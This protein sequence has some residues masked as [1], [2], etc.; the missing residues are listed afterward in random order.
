MQVFGTG[1]R[2]NDTFSK[3][4]LG[5]MWL[6]IFPALSEAASVPTPFGII[7]QPPKQAVRGQELIVRCRIRENE[8]LDEL[9]LRFRQGGQTQYRSVRMQLYQGDRYRIAIEPSLLGDGILEYYIVAVDADRKW[10][11]LFASARKPQVVKIIAPKKDKIAPPTQREPVPSAQPSTSK[12]RSS[13]VRDPKLDDASTVI[14]ATR[15]EQLIQHAPAVITV[16][17]SEDIQASGWRNVVDLLRYTV[18]IDINDNGHSPDLGIRGLNPSMSFGDKLQILVDG[19]N[20]VWRQFNRNYINPSWVSIDNIRRIEII[21][22]PG[23]ALW[24]AN[25]MSG[26]INIITKS[27]HDLQ[28]LQGLIGGSPLTGSYFLTLQGGQEIFGQIAFRA[29]FSMHQDHRSPIL[30]SIYEFQKTDNINYTTPNVQA[31]SR[32]FYAQLTWR[33]LN[34]RFQ[35]SH[36]HPSASLTSDTLLAGSSSIGSQNS[37]P[38]T[39]RYI[40]RAS[41]TSLLGIWGSIAAWASYDNYGFNSQNRLEI[42]SLSAFNSSAHLKGN[43]PNFAIYEKTPGSRELAFKGYYPACSEL[44]PDS[45]L[46]CIKL[47]QGERLQPVC[48]LVA[49][50]R[51]EP[52]SGTLYPY[53]PFI[54]RDCRLAYSHGQYLIQQ[55]ALDHRFEAGLLFSGQFFDALSISAGLELEYLMALSY[56]IPEFL[57]L[58][59]RQP[60]QISNFQFSGFAQIEYNIAKILELTAGVRIN[61]DQLY[62]VIATPRAAVVLTPGLGFYAKMLYGNAFKAPSLQD[63]FL[64]IDNHAVLFGNPSLLSESVHTFELQIGWHRSQLMALS[65]NAYL[66]LYQ[67]LITTVLR[68][69]HDEFLGEALYP[70]DQL[71]A[72][73][74]DFRQKAN[75]SA[76]TTYGLEAELRLFPVKHLNII[77]SFGLFFGQDDQG[78][79]LQLVHPWKFSLMAAYRIPLGSMALQIAL[80]GIVAGSKYVPPSAFALPGNPVLSATHIDRDQDLPVPS[81]TIQNDPSTQTPLTIETYIAIQ[82]LRIFNGI[83]LGVRFNN[84][85]NRDNYDANEL[86]LY[87]QTRFN[88]MLWMQAT[89]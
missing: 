75:T 21:R 50:P 4:I 61:Y 15:R 46:P 37:Y 19:H 73:N 58:L 30:S 49:N 85:I 31:L 77:S 89:L 53:S 83:D 67:N 9:H 13:K 20:M 34:L 59:N 7:H 11:V 55:S 22:G 66:S 71:P 54:A 6:A 87:P 68:D 48:S 65:L 43:S 45:K 51:A 26:V 27:G 17:T 24:G 5:L 76:M 18:G 1:L 86:L 3:L 60:P 82:L 10:H 28:G 80:G 16:L 32:N 44:P 47:A 57:Q 14:S 81:W 40:I 84:L 33:G 36:Y 78:Q 56:H 35:Q 38:S 64:F 25:A 8:E 79:V 52:Q 23:S 88:L 63:R 72:R 29:S 62:G 74:E 39:D 69:K 70:Q 12:K 42:N 41:W 2:K